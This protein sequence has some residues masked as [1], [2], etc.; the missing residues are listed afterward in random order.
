MKEKEKQ[1]TA[2]ANFLC[3]CFAGDMIAVTTIVSAYTDFMTG[4]ENG[5]DVL[6]NALT[7]VKEF[8]EEIVEKIEKC[9]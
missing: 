4:D 3:R 1:I 9:E 6:I 5:K 2:A 7:D 8:C